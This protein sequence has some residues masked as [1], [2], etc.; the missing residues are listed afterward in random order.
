MTN[1]SFGATHI[2]DKILT[3]KSTEELE[4]DNTLY[5]LKYKGKIKFLIYNL[6]GYF[7]ISQSFIDKNNLKSTTDFKNL[8]SSNSLFFK[9]LLANRETKFICSSITLD[10][11]VYENE[12]VKDNFKRYKQI[13]DYIESSLKR[14]AKHW[15]YGLYQ[16]CFFNY[17][18]PEVYLTNDGFTFE[19]GVEA[20]GSITK[21][22]IKTNLD[23]LK[24]LNLLDYKYKKEK[25]SHLKFNLNKFALPP[26]LIPSIFSSAFYEHI[27]DEQFEPINSQL[28]KVGKLKEFA[29]TKEKEIDYVAKQIE[30][31]S[32]GRKSEQIA[33]DFEIK[34][35]EAIGFSECNQIVKL[36]SKDNS[37]GYDILSKENENKE[38]YIEVK[39][40]K[41]LN[42]L[43]SFH[44]TANEI[45]KLQQLS[46]YYIYII[47]FT[48]SGQK[49]KIID[50]KNMLDSEY[51]KVIP[52]DYK[53]YLK[54]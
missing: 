51:F 42:E 20:F 44:I 13:L 26:E 32:V 33:L 3:I 24:N 10:E 46:N 34:R 15:Y 41:R 47:E 29:S 30:N 25:V 1:L 5:E 21:R 31:E 22:T 39:T 8:S 2:S 18:Y 28:K 37:L 27:S 43:V 53:I 36:V 11:K 19:N 17:A 54:N 35:L 4:D 52:T 50:T 38:R 49:V 6:S 48:K 9:Q 12:K 16:K 45:Q 14:G 7:E 23:K 40:V